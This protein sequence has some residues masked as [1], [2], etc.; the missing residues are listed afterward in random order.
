MNNKEFAVKAL[1]IAENYKTVYANGM[2]GSL[3]TE[4]IIAQ[5]AGQLPG[6]Y[7]TTRQTALRSLIGKGYFGFDCVCFVK[8]ILWGWDGSRDKNYGG[9][10]YQS[11]GVPDIDEGE[12]LKVCSGV[13][14]DFT[15]IVP[16]EYLWTSGHCGIYV[17]D[18]LAVECTPKWNNGVQITAVANM[19]EKYG[20]NNRRWEK[21]GKL[22]YVTYL[23]EVAPKPEQ[24]AGKT[25]TIEL[26]TLR[27][28]ENKGNAQIG[29]V[30]RILKLMGYYFMD[31]DCS[32]GSGTEMAVKAFQ[33]D[34]KLVVDGVV[35]QNTWAALLK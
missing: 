33:K 14:A 32:F 9:A 2:F 20:Y 11:N 24:P 18:G 30:Q 3:V 5:K 7:T 15:G 26:L 13:S 12:M 22:P 23:A 31:I 29:T 21:H 10:K 28:G 16:G 34:K 19:G 35:G 6:W 1:D 4:P 25:V 27:R 17:G 8:A